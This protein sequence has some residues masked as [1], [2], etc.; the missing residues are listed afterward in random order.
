LHAQRKSW[1]PH[2]KLP[3]CWSFYC[4]NDNT[5][6]DLENREIMR[7]ILCYQEPVIGINSKTQ[8]RKGLISYCKKNGT[9]S[10]K[11]MWMQSTLL[12]HKRLKKK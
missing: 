3:L 9:T 5:E 4:V 1:Q 2:G 10:L 6:I 8:A 11:N 12:L 7:C